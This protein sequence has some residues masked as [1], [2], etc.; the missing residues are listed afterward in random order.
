MNFAIM[1]NA[2]QRCRRNLPR[3]EGI[4]QGCRRTTQNSG[5]CIVRTVFHAICLVRMSPHD[6]NRLREAVVSKKARL[7]SMRPLSREALANLEHYYDIELTYTSNATEGNT[8][9]PVETT[10]VI[11]QGVN[12]RRQ[13]SQRPSGGPGPLRCNPLRPGTGAAGNTADGE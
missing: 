1:D 4:A 11:E 13:A 8:L 3:A 9:S 6:T 12:Y 5:R 2:V 10:L 7:D